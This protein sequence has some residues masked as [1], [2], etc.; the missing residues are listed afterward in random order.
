MTTCEWINKSVMMDLS[1]AFH[2]GLQDRF[3]TVRGWH[4]SSFLYAFMARLGYSRLRGASRFTVKGLNFV[5][6]GLGFTSFGLRAT[7]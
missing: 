2:T 3:W 4:R 5:Q 6:S 1:C 7:R